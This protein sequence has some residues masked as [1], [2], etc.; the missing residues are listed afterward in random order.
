MIRATVAFPVTVGSQ[1]VIPVGTYVEGVLTEIP[2]QT[3]AWHRANVQVHF[4]RL[5]FENGYTVSLDAAKIGATLVTP[6]TGDPSTYEVAEGGIGAFPLGGNFFPAT[7]ATTQP[8]ALPRVGPNPV[9][10]VV[11]VL[12]VFTGLATALI[13]HAR[14]VEKNTDYLIY[15]SGWNFQMVLDSPLIVDLAKAGALVPPP[16]AN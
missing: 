16:A 2:A 13:I 6:G 3:R 5:I 10:I 12:G 14:H 1:M 9:E 15:N 7:Q 8:P 11:P 4:T